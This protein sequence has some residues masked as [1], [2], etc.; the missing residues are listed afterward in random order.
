MLNGAIFI[1][2]AMINI[3][4]YAVIFFVDQ[5]VIND[6][7]SFAKLGFGNGEGVAEKFLTT[8][9][10]NYWLFLQQFVMHIRV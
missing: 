5:L 4:Q 1:S 10:S 9:C 7:Y 2:F 3:T 8:L 6:K